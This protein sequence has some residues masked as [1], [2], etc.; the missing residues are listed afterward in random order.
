MTARLL[1]RL[2]AACDAVL[3]I[4]LLSSTWDALYDFLGL[5]V[6]KPALYAQLLGAALVAFAIVEW[7]LAGR[8][9]SRELAGAVTVGSVLAAGILLVW[10]LSGRVRGDVHGEVILWFVAALLALEAA[11]HARTWVRSPG[12]GP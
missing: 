9:G 5:P 10:L 1:F 12:P 8:P 3:A 4:F 2:D 11:L 7:T 6:P